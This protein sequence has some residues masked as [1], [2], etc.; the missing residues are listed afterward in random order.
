[1]LFKCGTCLT[2]PSTAKPSLRSSSA[3]L[4]ACF[5]A[6]RSERGRKRSNGRP[7]VCFEILPLFSR[8]T[9]AP[10]EHSRGPGKPLYSSRVTLESFSQLLGQVETVDKRTPDGIYILIEVVELRAAFDNPN[11]VRSIALIT[12]VVNFNVESPLRV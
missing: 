5:S 7:S 6:V 10:E 3:R 4:L 8:P 11:L 9:P 12:T 1:M 2:A